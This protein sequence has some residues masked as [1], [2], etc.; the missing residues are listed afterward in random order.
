MLDD[1]RAQPF[2]AELADAVTSGEVFEGPAVARVPENNAQARI[3]AAG[4]AW[5]GSDRESGR[6]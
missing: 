1:L 3:G 5:A 6:I 2:S 4:T